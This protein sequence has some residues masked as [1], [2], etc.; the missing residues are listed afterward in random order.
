MEQVQNIVG[1]TIIII[2]IIFIAFGVIG[3]FR[4]K[5]FYNRILA[6]SNIDTVGVITVILGVAIKHGISAFTGKI[7]ILGIIMII[8]SPLVAHIITQSAHAS[9]HKLED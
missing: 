9:G 4:F 6:S 7:L 2:G 8:F 1:I 3:L 5:T